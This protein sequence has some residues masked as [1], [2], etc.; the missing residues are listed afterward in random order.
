MMSLRNSQDLNQHKLN[1]KTSF[2]DRKYKIHIH[3]N[4]DHTRLNQHFISHTLL[5]KTECLVY[6]YKLYTRT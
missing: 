3:I 1:F 6:R 2:R 4:I 5:R